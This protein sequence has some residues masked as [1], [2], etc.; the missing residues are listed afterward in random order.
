MSSFSILVDTNTDIPQEYIDKHDIMIIP[1]AFHLD[2]VMHNSGDW[3]E[4]S[5]TEFY[6]ALR[7]GSTAGTAL[8]NQEAFVEIFTDFATQGKQLLVIT[9]SSELSGTYQNAALACEDVKSRF[10]DCDIHV[11]DSISAAG[12]AGILTALAIDKREEGLTAAETAKWLEEKKHSCLAVFTVDDLMYLH[13]G[14]RLSKL[15]AIAGSIIGIKPLLNVAPDGS[16]RLKDRARGRSTAISTL[17][18]QMQRT[19]NPDT[20]LNRVFISHSDCYDDAEKLAEIIRN[21]CEVREVIVEMMGPII[22]THV[23]PGA[24]ALFYESDMTR[25]EYE[26]KF[27]P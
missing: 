22:G 19:L 16:L 5:A 15:S 3:K 21:G 7:K 14:G 26:K 1:I 8:A 25:V 24:I 2:E 4:I 10:P 18:S 11:V 23:G 27:Y 6:N 9:L 20:K 17:F 13:R 12:G